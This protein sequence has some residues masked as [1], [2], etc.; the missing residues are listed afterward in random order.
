M[1]LPE[2]GEVW[3]ADVE[4]GARPVVVLSRD[5]AIRGRR[6]SMVAACSTTVRG[7][8]SEVRLEPQDDPVPTSCVVQL[9]AVVDVA[10]QVLTHRLGRLGSARMSQVCRALAVATGCEGPA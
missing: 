5:A 3:W 7:L 6:R 9:D 10:T 2:R 4:V 1:D 8:P